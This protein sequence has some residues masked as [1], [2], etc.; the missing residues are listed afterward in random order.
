MPWLNIEYKDGRIETE[1]RDTFYD[2]TETARVRIEWNDAEK[3]T[4]TDY[5]G[6]EL[7]RC[8]N[9]S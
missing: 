6:N 5:L 7:A 8:Y 1:Y 9:W 2:A 3:V 4:I